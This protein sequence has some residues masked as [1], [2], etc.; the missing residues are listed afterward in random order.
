MLRKTE[1]DKQLK[2]RPQEEII[3]RNNKSIINDQQFSFYK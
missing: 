3:N 2:I 1:Y